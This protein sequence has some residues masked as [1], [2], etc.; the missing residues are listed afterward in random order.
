MKGI[1]LI[2]LV[3]IIIVLTLITIVPVS[4]HQNVSRK[5]KLMA[6]SGV[7]MSYWD[8]VWINPEVRFNQGHLTV[9]DSRR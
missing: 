6:K 8:V 9:D 7:Y 3:T 4:C 1:T 5:Q 2:E